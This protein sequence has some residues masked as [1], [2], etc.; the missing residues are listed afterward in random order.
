MFLASLCNEFFTREGEAPAEPLRTQLG[1]SL[2]LPFDPLAGSFQ[3]AACLSG[4][5]QEKMV[6]LTTFLCVVVFKLLN[7]IP[8]SRILECHFR[9][10]LGTI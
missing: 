10:W 8:T 6:L 3:A 1:R 9:H 7:S 2:A 4:E 5:S